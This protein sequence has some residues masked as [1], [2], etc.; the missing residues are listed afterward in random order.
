MKIV[1]RL[2]VIFL[3]A[4]ALYRFVPT[5]LHYQQFKDAVAETA[6]FAKD[7]SDTDIVNR[8]LEL[9]T[10]HDVPLAREYVRVRRQFGQTHI[11]ATWVQ[12]IQWLPGYE[13]PWQFEVG[14]PGAPDPAATPR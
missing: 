11:D 12:K 8:V 2:A 9:A 1:I 14:N 10:E 4:H 6:M 13:R 5:Y 3:V 7:K